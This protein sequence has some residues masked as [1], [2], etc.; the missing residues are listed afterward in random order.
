MRY[1]HFMVYEKAANER[2]EQKYQT[3]WDGYR[4]LVYDAHLSDLGGNSLAEF[5]ATSIYSLGNLAM[6]EKYISVTTIA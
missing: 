5:E 2:W 4:Q 6:T 3:I 1:Y